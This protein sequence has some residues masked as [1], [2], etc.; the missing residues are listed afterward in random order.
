MFC[1][2]VQHVEDV[3]LGASAG[4][5]QNG[6][7]QAGDGWGFLIRILVGERVNDANSFVARETMT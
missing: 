1:K 6:S 3:L 2:D 7:G 4:Q 5:C